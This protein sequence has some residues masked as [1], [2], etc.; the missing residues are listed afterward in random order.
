MGKVLGCDVPEVS[1]EES[2]VIVN[3]VLTE[4]Y[5]DG[6]FPIG[7]AKGVHSS[8]LGPDVHHLSGSHCEGVGEGRS[9]IGTEGGA[10]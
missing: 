1:L 10:E 2:W 8:F 5:V 3:D 7:A 9:E 4:P 6:R